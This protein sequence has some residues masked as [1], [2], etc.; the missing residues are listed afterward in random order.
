M[1]IKTE[2]QKMLSGELY[3]SFE[4]ELFEER[5]RTI[6][7]LY[8]FNNLS[9]RHIEGRKTIIKKLFGST[10]QEFWVEQRLHCDYGYNIH[11]GEN[12][13]AN[14]GC[15]ILDCAEVRIGDNVLFA[16]GVSLYTAGHPTNT[17]QRNAGLEYAY[18]IKIGDNVWIGGGAIILPGVSIGDN[19]IIGAGSVVTKNIPANVI[20]VG[21]PCR[22]IK[23]NKQ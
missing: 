3:L 20:A 19:T 21:N 9:P 16:P 15:T 18:P 8:E 1:T 13:Y 10:G 23:E 2:K 14:V 5:Q 22:V 11:I 7:L 17:G 12:F 6:N 4:S